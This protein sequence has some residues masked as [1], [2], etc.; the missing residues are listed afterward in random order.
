MGWGLGKNSPVILSLGKANFEALIDRHGQWVRWRIARK[1][2]CLTETG[3]PD[4]HCE[5]CGGSG[6]IYDCQRQYT[7]TLRLGVRNNIIE[8]SDPDCEVLKVYDARGRMFSFVK[9]GPFL[10]IIDE[11]NRLKQNEI[12]ELLIRKSIVKRLE[13]AAS[14]GCR[15]WKAPPQIWRACITRPPAR[16]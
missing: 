1:C 7:D 9:T 5:K 15:A 16:W 13:A 14:I 12:L 3:Q 6:D 4:I 10:E 2:P 8:L 11:E